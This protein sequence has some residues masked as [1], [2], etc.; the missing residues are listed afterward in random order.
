MITIDGVPSGAELFDGLEKAGKP[1]ILNF[2]RGKD[3][4][5]VWIELQKRNIETV[6]IHKSTVPGLK[7]ITEDLKRFEEYFGQ[8]IIDLPADGF[9]R[10]LANNVW[11]TPERCAILEAANLPN[12]TREEWDNMMRTH[13]A[14]PDTWILDGVRATDSATRRMAIQMHGAVKERTRRMSPIWDYGIADV[15]QAIADAGIELGIDYEWY[16]RSIDGISYDYAIK[17][18]DHAPEDYEL[19]KFWF[20]L[21]DLELMRYEEGGAK[22]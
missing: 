1:V 2:S 11:Q 18:R 13:Y 19:L 10:R 17:I 8:E 21:I 16:G 22:S 6:A 20:P 3:S 5:A 12:P 15:R 4:V 9:Y 14:E 7:F